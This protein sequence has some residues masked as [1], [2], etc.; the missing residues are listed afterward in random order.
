VVC[1]DLVWGYN[2]LIIDHALMPTVPKD[3]V[4]F[5]Y[6]EIYKN[7]VVL[8]GFNLLDSAE[9]IVLADNAIRIAK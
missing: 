6:F 9:L 2:F 5:C 3:P 7:V 1:S 4:Y 8:C